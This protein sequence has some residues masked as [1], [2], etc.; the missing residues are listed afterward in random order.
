MLSCI[1]TNSATTAH[2]LIAEDDP[3]LNSQMSQ[4]L[5]ESGYCVDSCFDGDEALILASNNRYQ[6]L[7]LDLMLPKRDGLSTLNIL[8]KKSQLPV[9]IVTAKGAEE[10]RILGLQ[11]GADDYISKPFNSTELLLRIE[12]LLRRSQTSEIEHK[13]IQELHNLE[14][15]SKQ[16]SAIF[17]GINLNFSQIQFQLLWELGINQGQVLS[18]AYLSQQILKRHLGAYDRSLDMHLS[19]IRRKLNEIGWQGQLQTIHGKGYCYI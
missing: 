17:N 5:Q 19:R 14:L 3:E 13:L 11:N 6:M 9:I 12:A 2:I 18:K 10:E 4:L 7:L 15:N 8:R 1:N 16:Q